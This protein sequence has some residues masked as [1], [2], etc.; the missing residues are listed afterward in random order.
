MDLN[1]KFDGVAATDRLSFVRGRLFS[2]KTYQAFTAKQSQVTKA[3]QKR[4]KSTKVLTTTVPSRSSCIILP[5]A[6]NR[7]W[8]VG[9]GGKVV[10]RPAAPRDLREKTLACP[11]PQC[12]KMFSLQKNLNSHFRAVHEGVKIT[13]QI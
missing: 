1:S 2:N 8:V 5:S 12:T 13:E 7:E 3:Q 10:R 4:M 11:H 6:G 9:P